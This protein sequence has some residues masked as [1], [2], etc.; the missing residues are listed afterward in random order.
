MMDVIYALVICSSFYGTPASISNFFMLFG[1]IYEIHVFIF[2][3]I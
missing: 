1:V 3:E 2:I